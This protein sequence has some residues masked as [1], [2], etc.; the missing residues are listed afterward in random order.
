[1]R[2]ALV[3]GSLLR[4]WELENYLIDG[5]DVDVVASRATGGLTPPA[6][7]RLRT[8]R[9][10]NDVVAGV[11]PQMRG[12]LD[13]FAGH[14]EYLL[15]LERALRGYDIAHV[16]ELQNPV[17]LQAVRARDRGNVRAVVATV[18]ENIPFTPAQ[19][20]LVA[21]R[22]ERN[23][24]GVDHF[25][26]ITERARLHLQTFGI[27]DERISV[28]PVGI[29]TDRFSP[30]SEPRPNERFR[31]VCV[32]RLEPGKGVEDLAIAVWLLHRRGIDAEVTFLGEG[33]S[34]GR[35]RHIAATMGVED[36]VTIRTAAWEELHTIHHTHDLF[37]MAS[38]PTRNWR[39]Q[40]GF[41][42]VEA[43]ASG[44]PCLVG[45]SGSLREV[46]GRPDQVVTPHDPIVLADRIA[47]LAA[48]APLR[49][50]LGE[51]NRRRAVEHFDVRVTR[52]R[53]GE[54]YAEV[55]ARA[56]TSRSR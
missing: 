12:V 25:L 44:L 49:R 27:E 39:E 13:Y 19:N 42:V 33:P 35:I 23:A 16:L 51:H 11:S 50:E 4:V 53:I 43:M 45:D 48:E 37:V 34:D 36:R 54:V 7:Q 22:V 21:K 55:L 46:V 32:A 28:V 26:A 2:V 20:P 52:E 18:M 6:P 56:S 5:V 31:I 3:R 24:R 15:G 17:T 29:P 47:E 9:S 30:G 14:T 10:L 8:L 1:M 41:A 40:F 38:A